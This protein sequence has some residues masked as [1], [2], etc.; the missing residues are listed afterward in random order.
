MTFREFVDLFCRSKLFLFT[1]FV[2]FALHALYLAE[3]ALFCH[4]QPSGSSIPRCVCHPFI[5]KKLFLYSQ[6]RLL[7]IGFPFGRMY[8]F[9]FNFPPLFEASMYS[10]VWLSHLN[11]ANWRINMDRCR[12]SKVSDRIQLSLT[13]LLSVYLIKK[14]LYKGALCIQEASV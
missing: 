11:S 2:I 9:I 3:H 6:E 10:V 1:F 12:E 7:R 14:M 13:L 4:P 8:S 5:H